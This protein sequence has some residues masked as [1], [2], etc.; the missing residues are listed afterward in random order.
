MATH[1][2]AVDS[3][4]RT[5]TLDEYFARTRLEE[6]AK[7]ASGETCSK[8]SKWIFSIGGPPGHTRMCAAC[9]ELGGKDE[10]THH[11]LIR[12]PKC[13]HTFNPY[14][15]EMYEVFEDEEHDISCVSCDHEFTVST[16]MS[17]SFT[18]PA[19]D[20]EHPASSIQNPES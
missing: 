12:C 10:A 8:C 19:M 6:K 2:G 20:I 3:P 11:K 1:A 4:P 15:C 14:D 13:G 17:Y 7:V 5:E 9:K 18:S 16:R